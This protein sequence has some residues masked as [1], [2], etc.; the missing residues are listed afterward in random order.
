MSEKAVFLNMCMITDEKGRILVQNRA[1]QKWSGLS[2]PG[3]HVEKGESFVK[4]VEREVFEE[5]GLTISNAKLC[6]VKQFLNDDERC[7]VFLFKC[8]HFE[9]KLRGSNEGEVF[10]LF[11]SE[12]KNYPLTK[13]FEELLKVFTDESLTEFYYLFKDGGWEFTLL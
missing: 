7:V 4:S 1:S 2:F 5:T 3:G 6:G 13:D 8:S 10:W 9:G 12:L 11:P